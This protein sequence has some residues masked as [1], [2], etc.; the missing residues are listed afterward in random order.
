MIGMWT[1]VSM[2]KLKPCKSCVFNV[3]SNERL[4]WGLSVEQ[5]IEHM[6]MFCIDRNIDDVY[7]GDGKCENF[8]PQRKYK[9]YIINVVD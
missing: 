1:M 6:N 3:W 8:L 7:L 4:F 2:K 5:K 9:K